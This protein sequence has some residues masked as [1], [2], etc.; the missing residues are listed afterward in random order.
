MTNIAELRRQAREHAHQL[1]AV[2]YLTVQDLAARWGVSEDVVR[3][4][5]RKKL[6]Y[7]TLGQSRLRRYDPRDV[8]AF[9]QREKTAE[10]AVQLEAPT[11]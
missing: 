6:P 5:E 7:I 3:D 10:E 9:E 4:L 11:P 2:R 8:E 1:A